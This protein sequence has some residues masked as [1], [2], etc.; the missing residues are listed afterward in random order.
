MGDRDDDFLRS[1]PPGGR[2]I[3]SSL[4]SDLLVHVAAIER[5]ARQVA[6]P[7]PERLAHIL[8]TGQQGR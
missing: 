3:R 6:E 7:P 1:R 8:P 4:V 2:L 5:L